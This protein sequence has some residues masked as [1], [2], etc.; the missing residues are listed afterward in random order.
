MMHD[1]VI[2]YMQRIKKKQRHEFYMVFKYINCLPS[3][4]ILVKIYAHFVEKQQK[5]TGM[6]N[7][8]AGTTDMSRS[9]LYTV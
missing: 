5:F 6:F 4:E 7:G 2:I 1:K 9:L 3:T 8:P